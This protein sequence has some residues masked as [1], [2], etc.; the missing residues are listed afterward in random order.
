MDTNNHFMFRGWKWKC[1][2]CHWIK[3]QIEHFP[4]HHKTGFILN[5]NEEM[6]VMIRCYFSK[7]YQQY[8]KIQQPKFKYV[9]KWKIKWLSVKEETARKNCISYRN[10]ILF[11]FWSKNYFI[12]KQVN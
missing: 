12:Y 5:K 6:Y 3:K 2:K 9:D 4:N 10:L 1:F 7:F 11:S 8:A